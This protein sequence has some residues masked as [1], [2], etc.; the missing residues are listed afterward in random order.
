MSQIKPGI[1]G[2]RVF[3]EYRG[4]GVSYA[5][6]EPKGASGDAL[7]WILRNDDRPL[8]RSERLRAAEVLDSYR[9]LIFGETNESRNAK[10]NAMK[11]V[12]KEAE[13]TKHESL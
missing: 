5:H 8:T 11:Q 7:S 10:I 1:Y 13:E 4:E 2:K 3:F 9:A 6:P 12:L